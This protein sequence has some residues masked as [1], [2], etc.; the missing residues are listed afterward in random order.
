MI[1]ISSQP[2]SITFSRNQIEF[3]L[4]ATGY[5]AL[6]NY[7]VLVEVEFE[8][9]YN[10]GSYSKVYSGDTTPGE[11]GTCH[12]NLRSLLNSLMENAIREDLPLPAVLNPVIGPSKTSR[13]YKF[14]FNESYG[15]P[16]V[17]QTWQESSV[18]TVL[19]GGVPSDEWTE[20]YLT[21]IGKDEALFIETPNFKKIG[22]DQPEYLN[23][24]NY[25]GGSPILWIRSWDESGNILQT[26]N[27]A[28]TSSQNEITMIPIGPEHLGLSSSTHRY[29][30]ILYNGTVGIGNEVSKTRYYYIDHRNYE[31]KCDLVYF[32]SFNVPEVLRVTG[33]KA[34]NLN[35]SRSKSQDEEGRISQYSYDFDQIQNFTTGH[36]SKEELDSLQSMLV[37]NSVY[38]VDLKNENYVPLDLTEENY[39]ISETRSFIQSLSFLA[40]ISSKKKV[41]KL[42]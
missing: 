3:V 20:D 25:S 36:M 8:D 31:W 40:R 32:N 6:D 2:E 21:T 39:N 10:T 13:K 29:Q 9:G 15:I 5:S 4:Q 18:K 19:L 24:F 27:T 23:W 12:F 34:N 26:I 1:T 35:V 42:I 22:Y 16:P 33:T 38:E 37:H 17:E 11:D 28:I 14:R 41:V 30:V 7:K